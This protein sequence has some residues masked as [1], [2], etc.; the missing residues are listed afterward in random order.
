MEKDL[1]E[2]THIIPSCPLRL[3][4]HLSCHALCRW[5]LL[6]G[7]YLPQ[8]LTNPGG[9][10]PW[11]S[12]S[13]R[14]KEALHPDLGCHRLRFW[15]YQ[16]MRGVVPPPCTS[17]WLPGE[18]S[19]QDRQHGPLC[20]DSRLSPRPSA[21]GAAR[22]PAGTCCPHGGGGVW[23]CCHPS[24]S[25]DHFNTQST[26]FSP[27]RGSPVPCCQQPELSS[28]SSSTRHQQAPTHGPKHPSPSHTR[29]QSLG[30]GE[31]DLA[32]AHPPLPACRKLG[33]GEEETRA[34]PF[35][36]DFKVIVSRSLRNSLSTK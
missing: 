20:H 13:P 33:M 12:R 31:P 11:E 16:M 26:G 14:P 35:A 15:R 29:P 36:T 3:H 5:A 22:T 28:C 9:R 4:L 10:I 25:T 21:P 19:V 6:R 8:H 34:N 1:V 23:L 2:E 32:R 30:L 24:P 17:L 27:S 18:S 7:C